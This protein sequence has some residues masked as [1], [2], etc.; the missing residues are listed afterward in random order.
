MKKLGIL[1][2]ILTLTIALAACGRRNKDNTEPTD[3]T[4]DP[5]ATATTPTVTVPAT[6][7]P[8]ITEPTIIEPTVI[9]PLPETNIPDPEVNSST[10][11]MK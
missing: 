11:D 5:A 7:A 2:L 8:T 9:D 3:N 4:T 10:G 6:T 1:A